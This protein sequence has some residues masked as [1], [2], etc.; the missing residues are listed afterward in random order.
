MQL[1]RPTLRIAARKPPPP[2][3]HRPR[4]IDQ[5][6]A[7]RLRHG[8]PVGPAALVVGDG[9]V[10][11]EQEEGHHVKRPADAVLAPV[12]ERLARHGAREAVAG[13]R[14][15]VRRQGREQGDFVVQV[16]LEGRAQGGE[17]LEEGAGGVGGG[18][19]GEV[20]EVGV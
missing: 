14:G 8:R 5:P 20:G 18:V 10:H 2:A 12:H 3:A 1:P 4:T 13:G 17:V 7:H 19:G 16:L 11:V 9:A 6:P 15:R